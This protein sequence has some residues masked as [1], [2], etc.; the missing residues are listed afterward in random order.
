MTPLRPITVASTMLLIFCASFALLW[1]Q[2]NPAAEPARAATGV[3]TPAAAGVA[4]ARPA[5]VGAALASASSGGQGPGPR[6]EVSD[7]PPANDSGPDMPVVV[8]VVHKQDVFRDSSTHFEAV[9]K[10]VNEGIISN[11]A[12][13]P[14]TVTVIDTDVPTQETTQA[15]FVLPPRGMK[16][17]GVPD[18]LTMASGDQLILRS[19]SYRDVTRQVP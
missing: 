5:P 16:H 13:R 12:D 11:G 3:P 14:L 10:K 18:G 7:V 9:W 4:P 1:R 19:P 8:G 15:T 2:R 6:P 17:F